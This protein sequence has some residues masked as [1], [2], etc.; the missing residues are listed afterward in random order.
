[1][2]ISSPVSTLMQVYTFPYCPSPVENTNR[3][4][5]QPLQTAVGELTI[6]LTLDYVYGG[7]IMLT[8]ACYLRLQEPLVFPASQSLGNRVNEHLSVNVTVTQKC[9]LGNPKSYEDR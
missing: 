5:F 1:M 3:P 6:T 8:L 9:A 2:A 4:V 7:T